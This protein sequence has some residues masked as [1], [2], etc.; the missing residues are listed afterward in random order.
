MSLLFLAAGSSVLNTCM[1]CTR[2]AWACTRVAWARPLHA[3]GCTVLL[4]AA[5]PPNRAAPGP[6]DIALRWGKAFCSNFLFHPAMDLFN[7]FAATAL[8]G[9][10]HSALLHS[11][12]Y[13]IDG[14]FVM[15]APCLLIFGGVHACIK[16]T[17]SSRLKD[18]Q[19]D[20]E[21][22]D[23]PTSSR[24]GPPVVCFCR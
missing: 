23:Q 17:E 4:M 7:L 6:G 13:L 16:R 18:S 3:T 11:E 10:T 2:V 15:F 8:L 21:S 12:S 9:V 1:I 5:L 19:H 20:L 24:R 14:A 22:T